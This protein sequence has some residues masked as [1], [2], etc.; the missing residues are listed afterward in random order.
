MRRKLLLAVALP[1]AAAVA[2]AVGRQLQQ[3][4]H[5]QAGARAQKAADLLRPGR[6]RA[7]TQS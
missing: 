3:R 7:A 1:A 5:E 4:G 6:K 2:G